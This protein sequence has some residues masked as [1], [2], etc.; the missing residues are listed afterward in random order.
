MEVSAFQQGDGAQL[1]TGNKNRV[2]EYRI[3]GNCKG[4]EKLNSV[5]IVFVFNNLGLALAQC[6][7]V[8]EQVK[9]AH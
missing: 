2:E 4:V 9:C 8:N 6:T 7:G 3:R 5:F 1:H